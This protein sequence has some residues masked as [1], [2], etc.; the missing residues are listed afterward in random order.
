MAP[1]RGVEAGAERTRAPAV[2]TRADCRSN[3]RPAGGPRNQSA[4]TVALPGGPARE[5]VSEAAPVPKRRAR[6]RTQ[7]G[8]AGRR[9]SVGLGRMGQGCSRRGGSRLP[10]GAFGELRRIL[11]TSEAPGQLKPIDVPGMSNGG[12]GVRW[13][14]QCAGPSSFAFACW[15]SSSVKAP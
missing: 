8:Q 12:G 6:R 15:N 9:V 7:S 11:W 1:C 5:R 14:G 3:D 4:M 10:R 2:Q 13:P